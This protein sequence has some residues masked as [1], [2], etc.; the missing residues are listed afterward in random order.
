MPNHPSEPKQVSGVA[1]QPITVEAINDIWFL[2]VALAAVVAYCVRVE[3]SVQN[4]DRRINRIET[5]VRELESDFEDSLAEVRKAFSAEL[6]AALESQREFIAG[7]TALI[8]E[9]IHN[10]KEQTDRQGKELREVGGLLS[11]KRH[12][13]D[14]ED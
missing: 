1:E 11:Y 8:L 13:N 12:H 6:Q 10:I 14:L 5:D 3:L 2:I 4:C 7:Q 9:K